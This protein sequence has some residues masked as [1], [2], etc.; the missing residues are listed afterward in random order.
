MPCL[1]WFVREINTQKS[2]FTQEDFEQ[3]DGRKIY[4]ILFINILKCEFVL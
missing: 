4:L 2:G 1:F 3:A